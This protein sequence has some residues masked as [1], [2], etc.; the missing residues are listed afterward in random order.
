MD[1]RIILALALAGMAFVRK[2]K[3]LARLVQADIE[4]EAAA[5]TF[6][7]EAGNPIEPGPENQFAGVVAPPKGAVR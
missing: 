2:R 5:A 7:D 6:E 3:R 4:A 1:G